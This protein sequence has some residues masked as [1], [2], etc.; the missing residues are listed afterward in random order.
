MGASSHIRRLAVLTLAAVVIVASTLA[1]LH[2]RAYRSVAAAQVVA[3]QTTTETANQPSQPQAKPPEIALKPDATREDEAAFVSLA[4]TEVSQLREGM[5]LAQWVDLHAKNAGWETSTD[6]SYFDCKTFTKTET[7]QSGRQIVRK[8]YFY[9]PEAPTPAVFPTLSGQELI[10]RTCRLAMIRVQ[11]PTPVPQDGHAFAQAAQEHFV[12]EYGDSIGMKGAVFGGAAAWQDTARWMSA[13][14]IVSAYNPTEAAYAREDPDS[15]S[16]FVFARLPVVYE[17]EQNACCRLKAYRYR[18]IENGQFHRAIGIAGVDAALSGRIAS[19]Y[20]TLIRASASSE[21]AQ[22]PEN[23]KLRDSVVPLLRDWLNAVK[24]LTPV[25]HAAGL[26]VA[27][28]LFVAAIDLAN[29][30]IGWPEL[31]DE[32][33]PELRSVLQGMG[34]SFEFDELGKCYDYSSNW[35]N[36]ARELDADGEVGRMAVLVSLARGGA[37]SLGKDKDQDIFHTVVADGEWLLAKN[38]DRPVAQVHFIIGDA[39]SDIVALAGGAEPDYDDPA[40]Y[41]GEAD[42]A[43]TKA[44]EH[45]RAGLAIDNSSENAKDAWLQAWHLAAGLLP[46]T[47]YVYIND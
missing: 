11:T 17:I 38:P 6:E 15:G 39:Y 46:T 33:K 35:L 13:F 24:T 2:H 1:I 43:R 44:L 47:R 41:R 16:V 37:P 22:Q 7:L 29:V 18:S 34:A 5:T 12:T 8:A 25:R 31:R 36:E 30:A 27:D 42:S 26:Y 4:E 9:P 45:Y 21:Q 10:D 3:K 23:A 28:R 32:D 40:K 19:L 14:E 20:E